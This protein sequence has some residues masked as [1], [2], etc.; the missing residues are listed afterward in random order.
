METLNELA[1]VLTEHDDS[2][3][4][5]AKTWRREPTQRELDEEREES[6]RVDAMFGRFA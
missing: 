5:A 2:T 4:F 6:A 3:R 1:A